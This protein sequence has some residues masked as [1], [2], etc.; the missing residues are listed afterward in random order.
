M[1]GQMSAIFGEKWWDFMMIGVSKWSYKQSDIDA[2]QGDCDD[3]GDPSDN[4][5]NE[6]WIKREI[7]SK[8][9]EKF[10]LNKNFSFVFLE[11][12]SQS[13]RNLNDETQQRYW[14]EETDKLWSEATA[15]NEIFD[16]KTIDEVL[17]ENSRFKRE[18]KQLNNIIDDKFMELYKAQNE[19]K[20]LITN[21]SSDI[22]ENKD[23][24]TNLSSD[25]TENKD[26]INGLSS[27]ISDY[28]TSINGLTNKTEENEKLIR[29]VQNLPFGYF[30][31]YKKNFS[32]AANAT[33]PI[34]EV[35]TYDKLLYSHHRG[36]QGDSP[37]ININTGKFVSGLSGTWRVDFSLRTWPEP[38]D[39]I[40]IHL[41]KNTEI[42]ATWFKS[43]RSSAA[44]GRDG[45]TGGR[46]LLVK[47]NRGDQ[48]YLRATLMQDPAYNIIFCVSLEQ[49]DV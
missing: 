29:T 46:S 17:Q 44:S 3:D 42:E 43:Y 34:G 14:K 4:C 8:L 18:I 11:A 36:L 10:H 5:K 13:G 19:N 7:S 2:R 40:N 21:L 39:D 24:I 27:N 20:D 15:S 32:K 12:Y 9:Q 31:G 1:L 37:G 48:L 28:E 25:I 26:M 23:L 6:A 38:G 22:T 47:L 33:G 41:V 16:F 45:N 49:P 35:I 30:C